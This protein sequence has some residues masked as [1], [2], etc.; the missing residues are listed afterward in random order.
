MENL[1]DSDKIY[2]FLNYEEQ[3]K[4][5]E[6]TKIYIANQ[7]LERKNNIKYSIS[8]LT[9]LKETLMLGIIPSSIGVITVSFINWFY[10]YGKEV[11]NDFEY[12]HKNNIGYMSYTMFED[13]K[14]LLN[15][16]EKINKLKQTLKIK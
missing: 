1:K 11:A 15:S 4:F 6:Q 16:E 13:Y 3:E 2:E 7:K 9:N 5:K 10:F 8:S 14:T 12:S